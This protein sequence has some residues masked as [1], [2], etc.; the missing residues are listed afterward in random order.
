MSRTGDVIVVIL[1]AGEGT[2]MNSNIAKV[3]H[4]LRGKSMI[5]YV[6]EAVR[7]ISPLRVIV[8][9]GHQA[10][11]VKRE[12]EKEGLEF[13]HQGER[14]GTGHAVQMVEPLFKDFTGTLVVLNG[15]TPLLRTETIS[16]LLAVHR[17]HRASATVLSAE[18][19]DPTGYGRIVRARDGSLLRIAE[20]KDASEDEREIREV[21]SGMFCF[22]SVDLFPALAMID[23][24]N[25]QG[26]YYIT[27][28]IEILRNQSKRVAGY[29]CDRREEVLGVN[30]REQLKAAERM[31]IED[32]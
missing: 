27:D 30:D 22:E 25:V 1:A 21:N 12:L 19:E 5:R 29:L 10:E 28:V 18:L 15:D 23:R 11:E 31:M 7:G 4:K 20:E 8:V 2:R 6:V 24:G 26:E 9:V 3:L 16:E 13:V 14:L 32:G 17:R